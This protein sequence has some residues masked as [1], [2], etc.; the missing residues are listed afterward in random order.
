MYRT[1]FTGKI[2]GHLVLFFKKESINLKMIFFIK[3]NLCTFYWISGNWPFILRDD[4][5][6][7]SERL[8]IP[9]EGWTPGNRRYSWI[10][11]NLI[12]ET[13]VQS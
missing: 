1:F 6:E 9:S 3:V 11:N 7:I 5:E 2:I 8:T 12:I 4:S 10:K 13:E